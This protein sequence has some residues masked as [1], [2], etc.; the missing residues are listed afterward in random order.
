ML[1]SENFCFSLTTSYKELIWCAKYQNVDIHIFCKR[2]SFIWGCF[3]PVSILKYQIQVTF[4]GFSNG[5]V[6]EQKLLY[7]NK[8]WQYAFWKFVKTLW[9]TGLIKSAVSE[10][11]SHYP[12]NL[13]KYLNIYFWIK[14][15]RTKSIKKTITIFRQIHLFT[16]SFRKPLLSWSCLK[17]YLMLVHSVFDKILK[18]VTQYWKLNKRQLYTHNGTDGHHMMR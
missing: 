10:S 15:S 4:L 2:W 12:E 18:L 3:F 8:M 14:G 9:E 13:Q 11:P 6:R 17:W 16:V 5:A 7:W 1:F